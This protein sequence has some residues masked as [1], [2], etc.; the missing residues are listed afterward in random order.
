MSRSRLPGGTYLSHRSH[1]AILKFESSAVPCTKY[2]PMRL[3]QAVLACALLFAAASPAFA[4]RLMADCKVVGNQL[5]IEAF[6]QDDT[7][8]QE[9]K[10]SV[11]SGD[12]VI[13][14]GQTDEK[15]VW[16]CPKP[17]AGTYTVRVESI[18]HAA[19][20]TVVIA[21]SEVGNNPSTV[22][23]SRDDTG[24]T[25]RATRTR[26]P[27]RNLALGVGLVGGACAVWLVTRRAANR[28]ASGA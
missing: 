20:E 16:T 28:T 3:R 19:T 9:A 25:N 7:P 26:T 8:A 18:G 5:R 12:I 21:E 4:H 2:F 11:Q 22:D 1:T 27:W 23:T 15:G 24:S 14:Q 10:V 13:A 6:Y 17:A